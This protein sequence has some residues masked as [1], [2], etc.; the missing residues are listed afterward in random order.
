MRFPARTA[1]GLRPACA[2]LPPTLRPHAVLAAAPPADRGAS[3]ALA[4]L[5]YLL[6]ATGGA[7]LARNAATLRTALPPTSREDFD[8]RDEL[9]KPQQPPPSPPASTAVAHANPPANPTPLPP[10]SDLPPTDTPRRL[11]DQDQSLVGVRAAT[12]E[13]LQRGWV[14]PRPPGSGANEVEGL[15]STAAVHDFT[16]D[17]PKVLHAERPSYPNLA[18]KAGIQGPVLLAMVIDEAGVPVQVDLLSGHPAF[19]SEAE[20]AARMWRF[21]PARASGRP[22]PARFRLTLVFRLQ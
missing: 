9:P 12:D 3:L 16:A 6:L 20:R 2:E 11:P 21:E 13:E 10:D 18:R 1:G 4:A 7:Y 14:P 8:I 19:H 5:V 17:P 22:V 15:P